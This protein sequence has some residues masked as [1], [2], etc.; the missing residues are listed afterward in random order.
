MSNSVSIPNISDE[1]KGQETNDDYV[2]RTRSK[3]RRIHNK[4]GHRHRTRNNWIFHGVVRK[5]RKWWTIPL[6]LLSAGLFVYEASTIWKK[7]KEPPGSERNTVPTTRIVHGVRERCLK[8]S[9][10]EYIKTLPSSF[11]K[12]ASPVKEIVYITGINSSFSGE[13]TTLL[14]QPFEVSRF[15]RF[16]G[17]QTFYERNESFKV[18][19]IAS[20]HCGFYSEN[21]GFKVSD[22][23]KSYMETCQ[24]VV[25]TCTFGGGY[26][27]Y[28][29]IGMSKETIR[30]VCYAAFWDEFTLKTKELE[31]SHIDN[32]HMIGKWRIIVVRELPF[33]DQ[34][35]N[36]KIPK[37]LGHRLFPRARY[38]I[39]VDSKS[40]LHRDPVAVLEA[41]LWRTKSVLAISE[42][43]ARSSVYDEALTIVQKN[44][45]KTEE[46]DMQ[47]TQYRMDGFPEVKR[48]NE[49]KAL[50][51]ASIIVRDHTQLTNMFMC[52]WFNEVVRFTAHDQLSFPYV[53][54]RMGMLKDI[55]M[56]P[57]CTRRDLVNTTGHKRQEKP[58]TDGDV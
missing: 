43:G 57:V 32:D 16:T 9:P 40:Q 50:A 49:Q 36:S 21:G 39:W 33:V 25:S 4:L 38:S 52:A 22:E 10:P 6:V 3:F 34:R 12:S 30:K 28:Q 51:E 15:N 46:V 8:L 27:L 14:Q 42:H 13:K 1:E 19:E 41:L 44:K 55:N 7:F 11:E 53:M 26:D 29:P 2:R 54:W 58:N 37:M 17:F 20:V 48:F 18:D 31:G 35:M 23:D 24:I 56:Y 5:L 47:I 45:E